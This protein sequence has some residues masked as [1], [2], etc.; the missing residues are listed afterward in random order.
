MGLG[1]LCSGQGGQTP[2]MFQALAGFGATADDLAPAAQGLGLSADAL[3]SAPLSIDLHAN[4]VAQPAI[5]GY[6]M[7]AWSLLSRHLPSPVLVAGYSLG[8]VVAC[9]VS[10]MIDT[11]PLMALVAARARLMDAEVAAPQ[12][13]LAL[14]GAQPETFQ[15]IARD[16]G[17]SVAIINGPDHVVLGGLAADVAQAEQAALQAGVPTVR[18][19]PVTVASHTPVLKGAVGPFAAELARA[20]VK[21]PS[22]PVL[23]GIDGDAVLSVERLIDVLP[24]QIAEPIRWADCMEQL[25]AR[26]VTAV[27]ELGPGGSLTKMLNDALPDM[28]ARALADFRTVSGVAAWVDR[29]LG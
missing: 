24:R 6:A 17:L 2:E 3:L 27:L 25:A 8:E 7:T 11:A 1:I 9:G 12:G 22:V 14:N 16:H 23:A 28:P 15:V 4:A 29:Q 13:M 20:G 5:A 21:S 18:V 10:G 19:L 26:G